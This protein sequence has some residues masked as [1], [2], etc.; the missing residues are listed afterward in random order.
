MERRIGRLGIGLM[1]MFVALFAQLTWL[2]V[3]HGPA[4]ANAP[5]NTRNAVRDFGQARGSMITADGVV[6]ARSVRNPNR[7][8]K[9]EYLREYPEKGRYAHVGGY[10]SFTYGTVGLERQ[11]NAVLAGHQGALVLSKD[12]I[13]QILQDR[14]EVSDLTLTI[15]DSVQRAA[16]EGLA[17]RQGSVVAIDVRTGAVL[18]LYSFPTFDPGP[19]A[20]LDTASVTA[21]WK[22]LQADDTKPTLA[23]AYRQIYPP[24][25]TFKTVTT[26]AGL[27]SG[28]VTPETPYPILSELPLPLST[29]PLKNFGGKSCGGTLTESFVVSC[30]TS[31]AQLGLDLGA[32]KLGAQA[33]AFGFGQRPPLDV[34]PAPVASRFPAVSFYKRNTP[35]LAQSAIG[36]SEVAATPLQ[37]ALVAAG[38]ANQGRIPKPYLV[39]KVQERNGAIV[40]RAERGTWLTAISPEVAQQITDMMEQVVLRGSGTRAAIPGVRVAAKTGTAQTT[41]GDT[42]NGQAQLR[43]HA[44]TIGFAPIEAPRVAIAVIIENQAEVSSTTGGRIAAPVLSQVM[45]AALAVTT[46]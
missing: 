6:I 9:Y 31:F 25:S 30:N 20:S 41:P 19:L 28:L 42:A 34:S 37:M 26:A 38:I 16:Q 12:K 21:A 40:S 10:F 22:Q 13:S 39:E 29:R 8:S 32:D 45:S 35:A 1:V 33:Q 2:Q 3:I 23:R 18:A 27:T 46:P 43:S 15:D 7:E 17:G 36:Q 4:L 11:Y 44:W 24:G 5:G 14:I